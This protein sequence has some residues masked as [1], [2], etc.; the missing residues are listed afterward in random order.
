MC[1]LAGIMDLRGQRPIDPERLAAM[2]ARIA[3]RGPDG[4]GSHVEP[5]LGLVHR[6]LAIIDLAGGAQPMANAA[7]TIRIVFN[8]EI[9]NFKALMDDLAGRGHRFATRCDTEAIV[10]GWAEWGEGVLDRLR[11][12]FAFALWDAGRGQLILARDRIGEK[13]LYYA[14]TPAGEL[15][16]ASEISGVLAALPE[17]PPLD[18][19]AVENYFA[20]GYVP[21]PKSIFRGIA[22]LA[23]G[24]L[25]V[26]GRGAGAPAVRQYWDVPLGDSPAM[27]AASLEE[28]LRAR[29]DAATRMRMVSDVPLGAFLSGGVDSGGVVAMMAGASARPVVTCSI[30]F[31][32]AAFDESRYAA[33]VAER[34]GTAHHRMTVGIDA[35]GLIDRLAGV[36]GEPF[37]DSSALPTYLVSG[38][39]RRHVTVALTG[40]GGDESF[41]GYRRHAFHLREEQ[42]KARFPEALRRPVFGALAAAWP[43]L[44]WA[45]R[46][47]RGKATCEALASDWIGGY[48]RAVSAIP[49]GLRH[50]LYSPD[51][52]RQLDGYDAIEVFRE[53]GK[54]VAGADPLARVQ[55]LDFKTWL[56]GGMLTKVDRASMA[57][58]LELRPPLLDHELVAWAMSL[59][60]SCKVE[61]FA[62]KAILKRALAPLL[63]HELLHRP[64]MGFSIPLADWLRGALAGRCTAL[65]EG[66]ALA[67]SGLFD[68]AA[69]RRLVT[70]HRRGTR[71]HA[72]ALWALIMFEAFLEGPAAG[73]GL[74][75]VTP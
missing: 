49:A 59:P 53:H 70:E 6:R 16:F 34:Y 64:K 7:G 46:W 65:A 28:E 8:G 43:K 23:P 74:P 30:A 73:A 45:P 41:A 39:A 48:G 56:P 9:Y 50:R 71:D 31:E 69:I 44:D 54:A 63:P 22:K 5:G 67:A 57:H 36:Y 47:L 68:T 20:Y 25:L 11:G 72:R 61:G 32:E 37:A 35:G 19:Q 15:V 26:A 18:P 14:V 58:G 21:D 2:S 1:G 3:H 17:T 66:S 13:P 60:A 29:L 40:D 55:Y 24:E 52:R 27:T 10:H 38:L 62:G 42:L 51:F 12:M 75:Q 4:S 33:M